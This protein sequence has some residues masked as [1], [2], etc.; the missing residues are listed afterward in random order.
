MK[1]LRGEGGGARTKLGPS[2]QTCQGEG[3]GPT[4]TFQIEVHASFLSGTH[5]T[6]QPP[7]QASGRDVGSGWEDVGPAGVPRNV[8]G[9]LFLRI[10]TT[11]C[12]RLASG[13]LW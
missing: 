12:L 7:P 11:R 13:W 2:S 1:A 8:A 3:E 6:P 5:Q 9:V 10:L 4:E